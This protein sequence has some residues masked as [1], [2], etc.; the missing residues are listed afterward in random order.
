MG[1]DHRVPGRVRGQPL[2]GAHVALGVVVEGLGVEPRIGHQRPRL[3]RQQRECGRHFDAAISNSLVHHLHNP[4][5]LWLEIKNI[6]SA[7]A[8]IL[9]VDLMRPATSDAARALVDTYAGNE[10]PILKA[11]FYNSLL[12]AFTIDEVRSQ[13]H[14]AGLARALTVE[15]I[16]D[17]HMSVYG[18]CP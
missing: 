12:A 2:A 4:L 5:V 14:S 3:H 7:H 10:R 13:L 8:P 16:S 9:V 17:R 11:D 18:I 1:R 6:T 15:A